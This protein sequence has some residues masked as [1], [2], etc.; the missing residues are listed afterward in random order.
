MKFVYF[1]KIIRIK[2]T[3]KAAFVLPLGLLDKQEA[4][5]RT[6]LLPTDG[7]VPDRASESKTRFIFGDLRL[8]F[9]KD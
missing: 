5:T 4:A 7:Q 1:V 9:L 3:K 2:F 6:R 8:G